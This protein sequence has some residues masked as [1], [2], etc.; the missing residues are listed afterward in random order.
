M[1]FAPAE[2]AALPVLLTRRVGTRAVAVAAAGLAW[3]GVALAGVEWRWPALLAVLLSGPAAA[4][5]TRLARVRDQQNDAMLTLL[6]H[7]RRVAI[8]AAG[9]GVAWSLFRGAQ[10]GGWGVVWALAIA[11][12]VLRRPARR[13]WLASSD[14]L[15]WSVLPLAAVG[16]WD[17]GL[18]CATAYALISFGVV[19]W[20]ERPRA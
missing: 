12:L 19:Q 16:R 20:G 5:A 6:L 15:A 7:A 13:L 17:L 18:L 10:P 4:G 11:T 8:A 14:G 1:V 3:V 9:A 2:E